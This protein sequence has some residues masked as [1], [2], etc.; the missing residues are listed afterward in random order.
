MVANGMGVCLV[1]S[2]DA[3]PSVRPGVDTVGRP[4]GR[5]LPRSVSGRAEAVDPVHL[6]VGSGV[7]R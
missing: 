6:A 3:I 4:V 5:A 7:A 1:G 2:P